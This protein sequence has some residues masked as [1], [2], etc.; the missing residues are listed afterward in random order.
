MGYATSRDQGILSE[1]T[2]SAVPIVI[3][4][5][6]ESTYTNATG[7]VTAKCSVTMFNPNGSSRVFT[8]VIIL[9]STSLPSSEPVRNSHCCPD[10]KPF[11]DRISITYSQ[12]C[13]EKLSQRVLVNGQIGLDLDVLR[14]WLELFIR[15]EGPAIVS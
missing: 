15:S 4:I 3:L 13:R 8:E 12:L 14:D 6:I 11:H 9:L 2:G 10:S 5:S 1:G 7:T